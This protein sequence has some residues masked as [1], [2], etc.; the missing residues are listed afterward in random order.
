M[1]VFDIFKSSP[2]PEEG[3]EISDT[4][5][6]VVFSE[7]V[8]DSIFWTVGAFAFTVIIV[9]LYRWRKWHVESL[10]KI[11]AKALWMSGYENTPY[12]FRKRD[13]VM[14]YGRRMLRKMK[15]LGDQA[16][17]GQ[18][19]KRKAVMKFARRILQMQRDNMPMQLKV[20]EPPAEFLEESH[21][22]SL[23]MPPD[24]LYMLQSIRIFGHFEKP[25]FFKLCKFTEVISLQ[26]GEFLFKIAD[27]DDSVY[28]VQTGSINV[29]INNADGTTMS[30]KIIHKGESVTSLLSFI[31]VLAGSP[32]I[33]KT[34]TAK[35]MEPTQ[36][37]RLPMYAFKEVFDE[38]PDILVRV[39]QVIMVRLERVTFTALRNYLGLHGELVYHPPKAAKKSEKV[40]SSP[41]H[42][43]TNSTYLEEVMALYGH[44][45]DRPDM[46]ADLA[47]TECATGSCGRKLSAT[48]MCDEKS[49]HYVYALDCFVRELGLQDEDKHL[50]EG[51]ME[52]R[53]YQAG[54]TL[55]REGDNSDNVS[56]IFLLSGNLQVYQFR[57]TYANSGSIKQENTEVHVLS[58]HP[59]EFDGGLAVITGEASLYTIRAKHFSR[60][61]LLSRST[62]YN[63][64]RERPKTVLDIA[65]SVVRKLSPLVRQCDFALDWMF[66]ESGRAVFRQD[67]P[68]DSTYIVLSGRVRSVATH[69]NGKKEIV[70][71]YGKGDLVGLV[72]M[73]TDTT[74]NTTAMA[75]RDSELAK[76]PQGLFNAIKLRHPMVVTQL[77]GLLSHRLLGSVQGRHSLAIAPQPVEPN[78]IKHKYSTVAIVPVNEDVPLSA[79]TYELYHSLSAIGPSLRLTSDVVRKTLGANI[80]DSANEY[81]LTSWLAQQEDRNQ[82]ALYQCDNI[83]SPWT[84]R[85]WR[86]ADVI[87]IVGVGDHGP[88]VGS[89]EREID[90][91]ML[92]T[93]KELVILHPDNTT[94]KP[95][96]TVQWLNMRSWVM[97]HHHIQ[98]RKRIFTR[99]SQYRTNELYSKVLQTEPN[100]HSDFSRLARWLTGN[101]VGLVLGGG[102]ARGAAHVGML[103]A[104]Q[105][106]GIPI[107]MVGGVSI[108]ALMGALWCSEKNITTVTQKAREW[109]KKMTQWGHQLLDLTYPITSMFSGRDFNK[110]I[111]DTIG[112]IYIEDLWIPYF[113]LTTDI[114]ASCARVHTHGSLWRYIRSSMSL[115]G[116]M[117]P[118]CDPKDGHLLLDG[119]YVNNLPADVL[120]AQGASHIIAI[121]VG[122][123]DETN[124][125]DY[126]DYLSGWWLIYKK[127]NPFTSPVRVPNLPDIQSRLA[128]VSCVR[129]LEE[130]KSS[131]YCEY[132]R[133]PIDQYKTL[134][135]GQFDHIKDVGYV[136][137]K[138]VFE[139][140]A[141]SG[142][143]SLF[144]QWYPQESGVPKAT[145]HSLNEYTFTDLAQIVCRVPET[146][147][148]H[149]YSSTDED[150]YFDGYISEPSSLYPMGKP[151]KLKRTGGSLS[152]SENEMDSDDLEMPTLLQL[153]GKTKE[154]LESQ[155][156]EKK[157]ATEE[158]P[159]PAPSTSD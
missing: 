128:Y 85:C 93:Q 133:P 78:H 69:A 92:R 130:V 114:T 95:T 7:C 142:R 6:Y 117:P 60:V 141:K 32:S 58:I 88:G 11:A 155:E 9:C 151:L 127:F 149:Q 84:Q 37:I 131:D 148:E 135:F 17:S 21:E 157:K 119:G 154:R 106:A 64:M 116:Y 104:I 81:R 159:L 49:I 115:S 12:R 146:Y 53:E 46:L 51:A 44:S 153:S 66:L 28:V 19:R 99:R 137:G 108:G 145:P 136:H 89:M 15:S 98:C 90:R 101:S 73:I 54:A 52:V 61:A 129:Q 48:K 139:E 109:S 82:I 27:T 100:L 125:T 67:E 77:F 112:D 144:N 74:R 22:G 122:S 87:L 39:V 70:G 156:F 91:L 152:L 86:Q 24:V 5:Y 41:G 94:A 4:P 16:Y 38:S 13:K 68:S 80:L 55:I 121:D 72:E 132:I 35:A 30:L 2:T 124:L 40:K 75:V 57:Y 102:G 31:D 140:M 134:A 1:N 71:E 118:L 50:L 14:F 143:I 83:L 126:G 107:D 79:F 29:S 120:R 18:G 3:T 34:V 138:Q 150:V 65:N 8:K 10:E 56:L 110:T 103:K 147:T 111:R 20:L 47:T 113:T 42:R 26:A 123:Q 23:G 36:V 96:N 45:G 97:K 43:R 76:L 59:G 62:V 25:V 33:Y 105:E 63:V 158:A